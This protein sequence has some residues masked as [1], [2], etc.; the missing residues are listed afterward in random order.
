MAR[1]CVQ[2]HRTRWFSIVF[3]CIYEEQANSDNTWCSTNCYNPYTR[4]SHRDLNVT[5]YELLI[6]NYLLTRLNI[7][8]YYRQHAGRPTRQLWE[9]TTSTLWY[10]RG[11]CPFW[12]ILPV[13]M[14][15]RA[16][17]VGSRHISVAFY[18]CKSTL[19]ASDV[20]CLN[21]E[22]ATNFLQR[23]PCRQELL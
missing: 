6:V 18:V 10:L 13:V 16:L 14:Y 2:L 3:N 4:E 5:S 7:K 9:N 11:K 21:V 12:L 8:C 15:W 19:C 22:A 1:S 17:L 20:F 23:L